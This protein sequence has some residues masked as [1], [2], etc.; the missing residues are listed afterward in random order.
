MVPVADIKE[1]ER[2]R[3]N[4]GEMPDF[5]ASIEAKGI[6]Q[7]I[8]LDQDLNL[9]AGGR[10][11]RGAQ[12]AGLEVIPALIRESQ[13]E[14]DLREV[15]LLENVERKDLEWFERADLVAEIDKLHR[16]KHGKSWSGRKTADLLNRSHGGIN[17]QL[18]LS[19]ACAVLPDLKKC[20]TEDEAFRKIKK[21]EEAHVNKQL[22]KQQKER[23]EKG[24]SPHVKYA[25]DHYQ[26]GDA[27]E[28]L[29]EVL[30]VQA[31]LKTQSMIHLMEIDPPYG[32]DLQAVK[33]RSTEDNPDLEAYNEVKKVDY[34]G[35]L[36][37]ICSLSYEAAARDCWCIFWYGPTWDREVRDAL[38][39]AGWAVD[40]IPGIWV[41]GS[42]ESSGS[43]QTASPEHHLGSAAEFFYVA[44]KGSPIL[45]GSGRTN[46]FSYK[47]VRLS[48]KYH[49]TQKPVE[50][51]DDLLKTFAFPGA[52]VCIPFLGS[53][54]TLRAAYRGGMTGFG[55]DK[56][57]KFKD[58]FLLS[59][60]EDNKSG[61]A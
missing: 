7:P 18:Q 9:V 39:Y 59:L 25:E 36:S 31:E 40:H 5:V 26:I 1:G 13:G 2:F 21:L 53:G 6:V 37:R 11:L 61:G 44:R 52:I 49:P 4:Y 45:H 54:V 19:K 58:L 34:P 48:Q 38:E 10:R 42:E 33:K 41:K 29:E 23:V 56:S 35:F 20:R 3:K 30:Q 22:R 16:E 27:L 60:E 50:L 51:Y 14:L 12:M 46:V 17:R 55:W 8:T 28:G 57:K 24:E 47:P 43:G 32:I 15:E